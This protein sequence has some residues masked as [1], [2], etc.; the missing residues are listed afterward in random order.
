MGLLGESDGGRWTGESFWLKLLDGGVVSVLIHYKYI[1]YTI[2]VNLEAYYALASLISYRD[3][4][5][6]SVS[7]ED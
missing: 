6:S 7:I 3:Y 5:R 1:Q 2:T 4:Y